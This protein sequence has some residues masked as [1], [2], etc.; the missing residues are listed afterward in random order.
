MNSF[1]SGADSVLLIGCP[2]DRCHFGEG[3]E[4]AQ[5]RLNIVVSAMKELGL[6]KK[7]QLICVSGTMIDDF[8][9]ISN[10]LVKKIEVVK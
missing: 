10:D 2:S 1:V 6:E 5:S 7:A 4:K 8:L 3:V 9:K